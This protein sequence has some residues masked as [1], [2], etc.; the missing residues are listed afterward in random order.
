MRDFVYKNR[1]KNEI[2]F[3]LGGIGT[4]CVGLSGNGRLIDW[5]MMNRPN[6]GGLNGFSHFA[7][8]VEKDGQTMD[9]RIMNSP[10]PPPKSGNC[11]EI[12]YDTVI[13]TE[14]QSTIHTIVVTR[15]Y[16]R[17]IH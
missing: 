3:P 5:E 16:F 14:A 13:R 8:R 12:K 11:L 15:L 17:L 10:L 1:K 4:G 2:S 9:A 6:K 7:V